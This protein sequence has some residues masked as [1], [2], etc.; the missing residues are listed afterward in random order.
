MQLLY[1]FLIRLSY[2]AIW[3][4]QVVSPKLKTFVRGRTQSFPKLTNHLQPHDKTMW[5]H[6]ASLG[7]FEQG[8]PIMEAMKKAYPAFKIVVSFFSPS[9]YE[10]KKDAPIADVVVYLPWDTPS[11][12][13]RFVTLVKPSFA[14]FV[15]YEFWPNYLKELKSKEVPTF[16]VSGLFRPKQLFFKSY[17]GFYRN[18]LGN[19]DHFFLQNTASETLL[20][21]IGLTNTTVSGDTR[22]DRVAKQIEM[23]NTVPLAEQFVQDKL[24][25]V[26][27]STWP[28]DET[29]LLPFL[30]DLPEGVRCILAPHH[31]DAA[32][33]RRLQTALGEKSLLYSE[34]KQRLQKPE[35]TILIIDN[36]GLLSKLYSYADIAYVGGA[37]GSTGLHNILEPATF[38]VPIVIGKN[39]EK[40]PEAKRL[41]QLAG[42]YVV[43]RAAACTERLQHFIQDKTFREKTGMIAGHYINSNTGATATILDFLQKHYTVTA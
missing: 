20:H 24:C 32:T 21:G 16:L 4:L 6:C 15:K 17:G 18:A 10:V 42:L 31:V 39:I 14:F 9:G 8:L 34:A 27:G 29:V 33:I 23:D 7:E 30:Q 38:G 25:L 22:F 36:I 13:K 2:A 3:C 35:A 26:C 11:N 12:A 28:E 37:M 40:F 5:F 19:F 1:N 41:R 43:D